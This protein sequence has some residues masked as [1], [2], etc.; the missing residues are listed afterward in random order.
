[1]NEKPLNERDINCC[2]AYHQTAFAL[3]FFFDYVLFLIEY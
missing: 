1:M 2:F 3:N